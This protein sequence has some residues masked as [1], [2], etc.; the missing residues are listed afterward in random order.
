MARRKKKDEV[1]RTGTVTVETDSKV[2]TATYQVLKGGF[3]RIETGKTALIGGLTEKGLARILLN[4][5]LIRA[6]KMGL[7]RPKPSTE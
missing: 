5:D 4:E 3:V 7:C 1:L 2:C 6:D